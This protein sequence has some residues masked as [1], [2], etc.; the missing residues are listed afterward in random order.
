MRSK[1]LIIIAALVLGGVAAV[2]AAGYLRSARSDITA[3][4]EPV[5]V[6]VAQEDL[7]RGL[8][9]TELQD[10][11]LVAEEEIP[12]RFVAGDAV[13]SIRQIE[14]Q[15]LAVP[16]SAGEQLTKGRFQYPAQAGLSYTVP[17][18]YVALSVPVDQVTG[19][20]GLLKPGDSVVVYATYTDA[21]EEAVDFTAMAV[22]KAKVLAVGA[23]TSAENASTAEDQETNAGVLATGRAQ[24]A[25]VEYQTVTLALSPEDAQQVVFGAETGSLYLALLGKNAEAPDQLSPAVLGEVDP[26][27]VAPLP[28]RNVLK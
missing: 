4:S 18:D 12:R 23:E 3:E 27:G 24:E 13:S 14:G 8:S 10:Q 28:A 21:G 20:S 16:V 22:G 19:V 11:G 6:L 17:E 5:T 25:T 15:V 7:P 1:V 9:A 2:L 26:A